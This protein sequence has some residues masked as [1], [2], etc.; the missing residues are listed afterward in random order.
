MCSWYGRRYLSETVTATVTHCNTLQHTATHC[1]TL[2][3]TATHCL[4]LQITAT[5]DSYLKQ[6]QQLQ[7]IA[8]HCN[9]LQ[10]TATHCN[11]LQHAATRWSTLLHTSMQHTASLCNALQK[12]QLSK[13][14]TET[15]THC[16]RKNSYVY[17]R[18]WCAVKW[19]LL[20]LLLRK[21]KCSSFVW[22][23]QGAVFYS[24]WREW[25]YVALYMMRY[26]G[27][28]TYWCATHCNTLQHTATHCNTL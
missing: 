20:L 12:K 4:A 26:I 8:T 1:N 16:N 11:A 22:N 13:S 14:V 27:L 18:K 23:S 9:T 6:S 10:H 2:Q 15:A 17:C 21:K 28:H 25:V 5:R 7:H 3:H 24:H 19:G